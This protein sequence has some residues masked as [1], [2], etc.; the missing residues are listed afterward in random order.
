MIHTLLA[1]LSCGHNV[2]EQTPR[3]SDVGEFLSV[4]S[5]CRLALSE[6]S[7]FFKRAVVA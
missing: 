6:G 4:A 2:I 3:R 5:K 1:L 7:E